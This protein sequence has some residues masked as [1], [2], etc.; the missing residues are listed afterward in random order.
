MEAAAEMTG[1]ALL[2]RA[3]GVVDSLYPIPDHADA[4]IGALALAIIE[5]AKRH[6]AEVAPQVA[7][8][9]RLMENRDA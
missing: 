4:C 7:V 3:L 2:E 9:S 1:L 8:I 6:P 5:T